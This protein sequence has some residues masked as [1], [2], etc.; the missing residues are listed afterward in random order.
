MNSTQCL[1]FI[2]FLIFELPK[3][4]GAF[5]EQVSKV[6]AIHNTQTL[7]IFGKTYMNQEIV[8]EIPR[9][10]LTEEILLNIRATFNVNIIAIAFVDDI[11]AMEK[12]G[13]HFSKVCA[14]KI[15]LVSENLRKE[16]I[17]DYAN[18][19]MFPNTI[20]FQRNQFYTFCCVNGNTPMKIFE[21]HPEELF[22]DRWIL[23]YRKN[24]VQWN[25][26]YISTFRT[27]NLG[28]VC[29]VVRIFGELYNGVEQ[30]VLK[31]ESDSITPVHALTLIKE[32]YKYERPGFL[33]FMGIDIVSPAISSKEEMAKMYFSLP[34]DISV[35][36][37]YIFAIFY[38][39]IV[40]LILNFLQTKKLKILGNFSMSLEIL[41][42]R[43]VNFQ[44]VQIVQRFILF[45]MVFLGYSVVTLYGSF[46]GSFLIK[47]IGSSKFEIICNEQRFLTF[48][49]LMP[50]ESKSIKW[51]IE[52][53]PK[54]LLDSLEMDATQYGYCLYS[55]VWSI[56]NNF[57]K[58]ARMKIFQVQYETPHLEKLEGYILRVFKEDFT[59]YLVNIYSY[60]LTINWEDFN[61]RDSNTRSI[62]KSTRNQDENEG[63]TLDWLLWPLLV[64]LVGYLLAA[65]TLLGE[66]F[67]HFIWKLK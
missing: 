36:I 46:L 54:Y 67:T 24:N 57:Q 27:C 62:I 16:E 1:I 31:N 56:F 65:I 41:L 9:I 18:Q 17:F 55:H 35:W 38:F 42:G 58:A 30:I 40:L 32:Q 14:P 59:L 34:F 23:N 44:S 37:I 48:S 2:V 50:N 13:R 53:D 15:I 63:I 52:S 5:I 66:I 12:V 25:N 64:F 47:G 22:R 43:G 19:E 61:Y 26:S 39:G 6:S 10:I 4:N 11:V 49:K 51:K 33:F 8:E 20:L 21:I 3:S 60:G 28:S 7:I 45:L 29:E